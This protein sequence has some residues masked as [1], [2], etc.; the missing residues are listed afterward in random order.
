MFFFIDIVKNDRLCR[1]PEDRL[2]GAELRAGESGLDDIISFVR[3]LCGA[4]VA[5]SVSAP[6]L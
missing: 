6:Y 1:L 4:P 2:A 3:H 5:Q